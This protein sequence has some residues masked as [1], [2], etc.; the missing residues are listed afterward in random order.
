[1]LKL[2]YRERSFLRINEASLKYFGRSL[3]DCEHA[4]ERLE[5]SAEKFT[6]VGSDIAEVGK[7]LEEL[8]VGP[9]LSLKLDFKQ[10][11]TSLHVNVVFVDCIIAMSS[12]FC[13]WAVT[14]HE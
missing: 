4:V 6:D 5:D 2:K 1:M 8:Q 10:Q 14:I 13:T 12:F 7:Q 3:A 11:K 9:L